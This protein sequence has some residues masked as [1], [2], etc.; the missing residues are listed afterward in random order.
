MKRKGIFQFLI[1]AALL[2]AL[3]CQQTQ[4][5][6]FPP[7]LLTAVHQT[8]AALDSLS[9]QLT[10]A[11]LQ[12]SLSADTSDIRF[13][14]Q[15]LKAAC[16]FTRENSFIT[17]Q[18]ILLMTEPPEYYPIQGAHIGHQDI[19]VQVLSTPQPLLSNLFHIAE[20][21]AAVLEIHPIFTNDQ[22]LG[23]I[24]GVFSP[25]QLLEEIIAPLVQNTPFNIWVME[26]SGVILYDA[27]VSEIGLNVFTDVPYAS[28]TE[29][30]NTCEKIAVQ[31]IGKSTCSYRDPLTDQIISR[32]I[33]W[34]TLVH[35]GNEW[36][37]VW[38]RML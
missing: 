34:K 1:S 35:Q 37:F 3:S 24:N 30:R 32:K 12:L 23:F 36:K 4:E 20:G 8:E 11:A 2:T 14:L 19:M 13:Q 6:H 21:Y 28:V 16:R 22:L 9:L 18:A 29:L 38:V 10:N 31:P 15:R 17:P 5:R 33:F 7:A 25:A 26:R 27:D